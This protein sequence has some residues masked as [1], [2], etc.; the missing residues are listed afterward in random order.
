MKKVTSLLLLTYALLCS[1]SV[2]AQSP[3]SVGGGNSAADASVQSDNPLVF[4]SKAQLLQRKRLLGLLRLK[5]LSQQDTT[6]LTDSLLATLRGDYNL[7]AWDTTRMMQN[8]V[9]VVKFSSVCRTELETHVRNLFDTTL[10]AYR[11]TWS[12]E[13]PAFQR[14]D[15]AGAKSRIDTTANQLLAAQDSWCSTVARK[16]HPYQAILPKL[17]GEFDGAI[18]TALD[19]SRTRLRAEYQKKQAEAAVVAKA[20][21][22]ARAATE[23]KQQAQV[24]AQEQVRAN[25]DKRDAVL[26]SASKNTKPQPITPD[27]CIDGICVEQAFGSL[28]ASIQWMPRPP[29]PQYRVIGSKKDGDKYRAEV[30][31]FCENDNRPIWGSKVGKLCDVIFHKYDFP[32]AAIATFFRENTLAVCSPMTLNVEDLRIKTSSGILWVNVKVA[33]DGILR[34]QTLVKEFDI[35]K[36]QVP[37]LRAMLKQKH[38]TLEFSE[39]LD[40][41]ILSTAWGGKVMYRDKQMSRDNNDAVPIYRLYGRNSIFEAVNSGACAPVE[42]ARVPLSVK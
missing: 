37:E 17:L 30:R 4:T 7:T 22:D 6:M 41:K 24:A 1:A 19:E 40:N 27:M 28:P 38:P 39:G 35:P 2:F 20:E 12:N 34:V 25:N 3:S 31:V 14:G 16:P 23:K 36:S 33:N 29:E 5:P 42:K 11:S 13:G 32:R 21:E 15:L 10:E 8:G 26:A 9:P 18:A